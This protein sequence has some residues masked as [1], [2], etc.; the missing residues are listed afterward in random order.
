MPMNTLE[1]R[2]GQD[3]IYLPTVFFMTE[4]EVKNLKVDQL[5]SH[6]NEIGLP[7]DGKKN[8]LTTK[9]LDAVN[10]A[11]FHSVDKTYWLGKANSFQGREVWA[12]K[13]PSKMLGVS[14]PDA[15]LVKRRFVKLFMLKGMTKK[16]ARVTTMDLL[17]AE[18][19]PPRSWRR[20]ATGPMVKLIRHRQQAIRDY[21]Y[22]LT[23]TYLAHKKNL[24]YINDQIQATRL[25]IRDG[26]HMYFPL[27]KYLY[28]TEGWSKYLEQKKKIKAI[29]SKELMVKAKKDNEAYGALLMAEAMSQYNSQPVML[30]KD[31]I[32]RLYN[33]RSIA[34]K[35]EI[36]NSNYYETNQPW[37]FV[38]AGEHVEENEL[39]LKCKEWLNSDS[40]LNTEIPFPF[41]IGDRHRSLFDAQ[42]LREFGTD[43]RILEMAAFSTEVAQSD[44]RRLEERQEF[45]SDMDKLL[46]SL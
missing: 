30:L 46:N 28:Y 17:R 27:E 36:H 21:L 13:I 29:K 35:K 6:L 3:G 45:M 24:E 43:E 26:G 33:H 8:V 32:R 9:V 25:E 44:K 1:E 23:G 39:L 14:S 19:Y 15:Q 41:F 18:L 5:K 38:K 34:V 31:K 7:T 40:L 37:Y 2:I 42:P 11:S 20:T 4:E 22:G 10:A 16:Q 12:E